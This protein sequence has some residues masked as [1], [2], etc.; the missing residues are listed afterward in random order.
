MTA[1][2]VSRITILA[3]PKDVFKYLADSSYH[4]LWNPHLHSLEPAGKLK[5]GSKYKTTSVLLGVR[6]SGKNS[7]T[8][9]DA[10]KELQIENVAGTI[11]YSVNYRLTKKERRT[12]VICTTEVTA[13][14]NAFTF[15]KPLLRL[16][17]RRELQ[18]DLK[19]LKIAVEHKLG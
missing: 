12:Q 9:C 8:R 2:V 1:T 5:S 10:D 7:V 15:T 14:S 13:N 19:A 3:E 6:V 17:A 16:L 4:F 18:S 11:R